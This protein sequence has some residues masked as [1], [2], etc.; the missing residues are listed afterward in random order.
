MTRLSALL[1]SVICMLL[2]PTLAGCGELEIP[3]RDEDQKNETTESDDNDNGQNKDEEEGDEGDN[4]ENESPD[5]KEPTGDEKPHSV[6]YATFTDDGHLLIDDSLYL[7][8]YEVRNVLSAYSDSP[9]E[10]L[11]KA[12]K[13][14]E[15]NM[16]NGWRIPTEKEVNYLLGMYASHTFYYGDEPLPVLN[17]A[18]EAWEYD[19]LSFD[20]RYLCAEG[21]KTFCFEAGKNISKA[22]TKSYYRLRLVHSKE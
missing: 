16:K 12:E 14:E 6:G 11:E 19:L 5:E 7:S 18:L 2:L 8:V 3:V 10:A 20:Y 22:G 17:R 15:G 4:D 9:K 13:Y 21:Q 1:F